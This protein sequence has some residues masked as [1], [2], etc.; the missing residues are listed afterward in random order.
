MGV[1]VGFT[2]L[3]PADFGFFIAVAVAAVAIG[4]ASTVVVVVVVVMVKFATCM[5]GANPAGRS[6][7]RYDIFFSFFFSFLL[8]PSFS[9]SLSFLPARI[10]E[11]D[12]GTGVCI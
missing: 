6:R 5:N 4:L 2:L 11:D 10:D 9:C 3:E 7:S 1:G 8:F 12:D